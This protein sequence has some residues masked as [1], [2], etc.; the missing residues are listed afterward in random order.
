MRVVER[1]NMFGDGNMFLYAEKTECD[2]LLER[3]GGEH[4]YLKYGKC[5]DDFHTC[6]QATHQAAY[7]RNSRTR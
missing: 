1:R 7:I 2:E 4:D 6:R 3:Y 5:Q